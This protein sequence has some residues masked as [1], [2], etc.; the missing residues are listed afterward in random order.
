MKKLIVILMIS[1]FS[2]NGTKTDKKETK[3]QKVDAIINTD[4]IEPKTS[5]ISTNFKS[6]IRPNQKLSLD[7]VYIDTVQFMS[8]NNDSDYRLFF[9][10]KKKEKVSLIYDLIS[11]NKFDFIRGDEI[12]IKWKMDSIWIAGDGETLDFSEWLIRAEKIKEGEVSQFRKNYG[13]PIKYIN[14]HESY[15]E[16]YLDHL[17]KLVEYYIAN[18][19]Q[20]LVKAHIN[21]PDKAEFIYSIDERKENEK[22]Y[23]ILGVSS[24]FESHTSI[25]QWLYYDLDKGILYEYDL[26]NDKLI[27]F[28]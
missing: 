18:S 15:S 27:E 21:N 7:K 12:E 25:I 16:S 26:A 9:A 11:D 2:C 13:K 23:T 20:E 6:S 3:N 8:F 4:S 1:L 22:T 10:R 19:K 24:N 17:N 5:D 14:H 28:D